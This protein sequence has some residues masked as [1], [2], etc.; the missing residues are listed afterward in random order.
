M[1]QHDLTRTTTG[2]PA[3]GRPPTA[4]ARPPAVDPPGPVERA[5][6]WARSHRFLLDAAA[7]VAGTGVLVLLSSGALGTGSLPLT[8]QVA[9][10]VLPLAWR[11]VAPRL[12]FAL[13]A[14]AGLLVLA[15]GDLF[16]PGLVA[17]LV[18][19]H[20]VTAYGSRRDGRLVLVVGLVAAV[21]ASARF[22]LLLSRDPFV[23]AAFAAA[24][25]L[26]VV[27]AWSVGVL[28]RVRVSH[29]AALTERA[30][31]LEAERDQQAVIAAAAERA[32][33]AREMHDVVAHSLSVVVAQADGGRYAARADPAAAVRALETIAGTGRQALADMRG[34]LG[35]LRQD[36]SAR[37]TPQPGAGDVDQLVEDVR[38]SGLD[39]T[40]HEEGDRRPLPPSPG[41]AVYRIV[42]EALTNVMKHGGPRASAVVHLRWRA[43]AVEVEV[44]DDGRGAGATPAPA[45]GQGLVGMRERAALAGGAVEA[46]P[47]PRGG[48]RVVARVPDEAPAADRRPPAPPSPSDRR[49][50]ATR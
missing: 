43:G 46:G 17:V 12:T 41:L 19:V 29:E 31:L 20:A 40:L 38:R 23:S 30:R 34:L 1:T 47:V 44:V 18:T 7:A 37:R 11:R 22:L 33:I 48:W 8:V 36:D 5:A 4:G 50:G 35:V 25:G 13:V 2:P 45:G 39:V 42:Q 27:A 10:L 32:R 6:G 14:A 3:P 24:M 21:A 9:L 26:L 15:V 28:S 49:A 16:N